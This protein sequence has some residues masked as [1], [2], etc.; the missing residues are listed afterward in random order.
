MQ[1]QLI[2]AV[3]NARIVSVDGIFQR[4]VS[5]D[6]DELRG[7]N[8]G[9]RWGPPGGYSVLYLGRPTPNVVAEAYRHLVD[10]DE[11]GLL[12]G[13]MVGPRNLLTCRVDVTDILDL[14]DPAT[15]QA[16]GLDLAAL[17][18]PIE[19]HAVCRRVGQAAH[20]LQLHGVIAPAAAQLGET[21]A[22][23]EEHLSHAELP[24]LIA[25][26]RWPH[27]P[28]DPRHLRALD[29]DVNATGA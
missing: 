29:D 12:D 7:S 25:H 19:E 11:D 17:R 26:E 13:T 23:F 20:Q 3:A 14:C 15:R 8:S 1:Q 5:P 9:G 27:L 4:H 10:D 21:L 24:E 22:L 28:P 6:V 16:V 18:S 2:T